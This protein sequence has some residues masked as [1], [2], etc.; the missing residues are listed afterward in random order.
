MERLCGRTAEPMRQ[1][2]GRCVIAE[3]L[4][5]LAMDTGR[6]L[7][8]AR[9]RAGMS[10]RQ[11]AA[12]A[13]VPQATVGRIEAGLVSPRADT[14]T[15]LL[16]AAGHELT[17]EPRLGEGVDRSLIRARLRM[18]PSERIALA[19]QEARTMPRMRIRR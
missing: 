3:M 13:A 17:S 10:Q 14:L 7:R 12:A 5:L 1:A 11:L 4:S 8:S 9:R 18:T 16:R 15:R 19:V 6:L 2:I